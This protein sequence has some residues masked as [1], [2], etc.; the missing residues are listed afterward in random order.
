MTIISSSTLPQVDAFS[1]DHTTVAVGASTLNMPHNDPGFAAPMTDADPADRRPVPDVIS[2]GE[3]GVLINILIV[4]DE[5]ANLIV[6]ETVLDDPSYR[7][8]RATSAD[9]ALLALVRDEFALL[10]LDVRMPDMDGFELAQIVKKRKKTASV[11]IIFLTAYYDEDQHVLEG[12]GSGAVDFLNKPV[13]RSVLRS[14]VAVFAEL[15]RKTQTIAAAN[16]ALVAEVQERRRVEENLRQLNQTL[17]DRVRDRTEALQ[18]ADLHLRGMMSSI[19]D[20]LFTLDREW[21]VT[22]ANDRAAA[23]LNTTADQLEHACLWE[24]AAGALGAQFRERAE[25][26]FALSKTICF[27]Q[28]FP[29]LGKWLQ[30]HCYPSEVGLSVYF[31]DITDRKEVDERREHLLAAE[32]AARA[33]ADKVAHAKDD[34]L[35]SLSHE[36]RTPLAAILG[37]T[38]IL[39]RSRV[40]EATTKRGIEVIAQNAKAQ[41][42]LVSDLLDVSRVA[43]GKLKLGFQRVDMNEVAVFAVDSAK[44]AAQA[45]GV[46]LTTSL[47]AART[48]FVMGNEERLHQIASNLI[49]NALKFTPA[50]GAI[51]VET[52]VTESHVSLRVIDTGE[53]I[54]VGFLPH[55]FERFAQ[56]DS[57]SARVHGGLGLGLSIVKNLAELHGGIVKASSAGPGCGSTFAVEIPIAPSSPT[58]LQYDGVVA[59]RREVAVGSDDG[60]AVLTGINVL[61]VD[62]HSD[63]L[64]VQSRLL[65]EAGANVE[66]AESADRALEIVRAGRIDILLSDLG[67]PGTDGYSLMRMIREQ[68]SVPASRLPSAAVTAYVRELDRERALRE[69]FQVVLQKPVPAR[70]L[71]QAVLDL[72]VRAAGGSTDSTAVAITSPPPIA[73]SGPA[74]LPP[75]KLKALLVEDHADLREQIR[76]FLVEEAVESIE[77]ENAED[78]LTRFRQEQFDFVMT[79][80]SLPVMS[81]VEFAKL[82]LKHQPDTWIVFSTGYQLEE[83]L[84]K[85]GKNVRMLLKPFEVEQ[86]S[87]V[88]EEIREA[89]RRAADPAGMPSRRGD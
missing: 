31:I 25:S 61:L 56:V 74:P 59:E 12:Y 46:S 48:S 65:R 44:P 88:L 22:Y 79:D 3:G 67:M 40:D 17:E 9:E 70:D 27:D 23:L 6:L 82:V 30:C 42:K 2:A 60:G 58:H 11:P 53:G 49:S 89:S 83:S 80:I 34:F 57:S 35:A 68:L 86:L 51:E 43:S 72:A 19:T 75:R 8:V 66:T 28:H 47:E 16:E 18:R 4:D 73:I 36:L 50:G 26:A 13:N 84:R 41:S 62:D 85:L 14:K 52:E 39:Q 29:D 71:V 32:Q 76:W 77:C 15:N 63:V 45:K 20:A 38:T 10:I 5:P 69:G 1:F 55:L 78:A 87:E 21:R 33:V 24:L 7:I 37:W 64:E 81:G 54:P